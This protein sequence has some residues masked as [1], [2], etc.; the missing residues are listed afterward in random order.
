MDK[1]SKY[2]NRIIYDSIY[3]VSEVVIILSKIYITLKNISPLS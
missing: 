2:I 1:I 3:I